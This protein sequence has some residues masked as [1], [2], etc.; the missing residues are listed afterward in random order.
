M[1][2]MNT[3]VNWK[4]DYVEVH[5]MK[6]NYYRTGSGEKPALVLVH[7]FS[8]SGICW[9]PVA[10]ELEHQFD[11]IMP[12]MRG[13]GL[14]A[15]AADGDRFDM[16]ADLAELIQQL[17]L[18]RPVV[19]GHSMGAAVTFEFAVRSPHIPRALFLEDPP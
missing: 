1:S 4:N 7:G 9:L 16:A 11:V 17:D 19:G 15:R 6:L 12:D 2:G 3:A 18:Q 8:D 14:S 5:N 10:R 13:H